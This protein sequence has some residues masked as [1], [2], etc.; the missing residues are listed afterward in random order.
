[1][2]EPRDAN[3]ARPR[4]VSAVSSRRSGGGDHL[5]KNEGGTLPL[6][7]RQK[8]FVTGRPR[9]HGP[10]LERRLDLDLAGHR[11]RRRI[12]GTS[13]RSGAR[14]ATRSGGLPRVRT[15]R[16][17][18]QGDRR[19]GRGGR[20]AAADVVDRRLGE[21]SY[22]ETPG[23]IDDLNLPDAQLR[24]PRRSEDGEA[25]RA[26]AG[27]GAAAH[28][29][30]DRAGRGR[31]STATNPGL[32]GG[33]AITD[34]LSGDV[35]PSGKLPFTYPRHPNAIRFRTIAARGAD[36]GGTDHA[37]R[38]QPRVA[39]RPRALLHVVRV[40]QPARRDADRR[41]ARFR[42]RLGDRDQHRQP[43]RQGERAAVRA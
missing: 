35:N 18:R 11:R 38:L 23:N 27:R 32:E 29:A 19:R 16:V 33:Q 25:G 30:H 12:R 42:A 2:P 14:C 8:V 3:S 7:S 41:P 22:A 13:R 17:L 4:P 36:I 21:V 15:R 39:V 9:T 24:W 34:V 43:R 37:L 31:S 5:L 1:M 40:L 26:A 28:R 6:A 20:G 10:A